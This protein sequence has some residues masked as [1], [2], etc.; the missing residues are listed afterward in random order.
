MRH[1]IPFAANR[2]RQIVSRAEEF[3]QHQSD[4]NDQEGAIRL[5]SN[6]LQQK[7]RFYNAIAHLTS[8]NEKWVNFI[9]TLPLEHQAA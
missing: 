3:L 7:A 6:S 8:L 5:L 4:P 2:L 1:Q 9:H